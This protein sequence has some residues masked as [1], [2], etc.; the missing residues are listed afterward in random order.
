MS[1]LLVLFCALSLLSCQMDLGSP[2]KELCHGLNIAN[3]EIMNVFRMLDFLYLIK[4]QRN[5][6]NGE[7]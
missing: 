4:K 7:L 5:N 2:A 1:L 6:S 3:E